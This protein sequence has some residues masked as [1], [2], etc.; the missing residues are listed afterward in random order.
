MLVD[1]N[2]SRP[3]GGGA[4]IE[5]ME[6]IKKLEQEIEEEKVRTQIL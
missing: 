3:T 6:Y 1:D 4:L 5:E 2:K